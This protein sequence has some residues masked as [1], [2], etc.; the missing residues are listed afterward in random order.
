[1]R[2]RLFTTLVITSLSGLIPA[3]HAAAQELTSNELARVDDWYR[4]TSGRTGDREWGVAIGT[5]H[6][7]VLWTVNPESELIPA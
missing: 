2:R 7:R 1:M 3:S 5:M 4:R 6:G